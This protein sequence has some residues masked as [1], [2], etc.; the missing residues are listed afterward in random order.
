MAEKENSGLLALTSVTAGE[1]EAVK[2]TAEVSLVDTGAKG[3][4]PSQGVISEG[5]DGSEPPPMLSDFGGLVSLLEANN[6]FKHK[7]ELIYGSSATTTAYWASAKFTN[8]PIPVQVS[9]AK[10]VDLFYKRYATVFATANTKAFFDIVNA[11]SDG[12]RQEQ[13]CLLMLLDAIICRLTNQIP[14]DHRSQRR[15]YNHHEEFAMVVLIASGL[16]IQPTDISGAAAE[17]IGHEGKRRGPQVVPPEASSPASIGTVS[18]GGTDYKSGLADRERFS[19]LECD[20]ISTTIAAV[21]DIS[22]E[23]GTC[24]SRSPPPRATDVAEIHY[25]WTSIAHFKPTN[26]NQ[27]QR[28]IRTKIAVYNGVINAGIDLTNMKTVLNAVTNLVIYNKDA[29]FLT[30]N[31]KGMDVA[32][33]AKPSRRT[34]TSAPREERYTQRAANA[35]STRASAAA[36]AASTKAPVNAFGQDG[37][38]FDVDSL[39]TG[40]GLPTHTLSRGL[41]Q[42]ATSSG[43]GHGLTGPPQNTGPRVRRSSTYTHVNN[44]MLPVAGGGTGATAGSNSAGAPSGS[45]GTPGSI[46]EVG[47]GELAV[48]VSELTNLGIVSDY[49]TAAQ[50][51]FTDKVVKKRSRSGIPSDISGVR[52]DR[53]KPVKVTAGAA[54]A[55]AAHAA[56]VYAASG[57]QPP[58]PHEPHEPVKRLRSAPAAPAGHRGG[59]AP[60]PAGGKVIAT[61]A[62][63]SRASN[64]MYPVQDES[65]ISSEDVAFQVHNAMVNRV[66]AGW[67]QVIDPMSDHPYYLHRS[68]GTMTTTFPSTTYLTS[69]SGDY[70]NMKVAS[71]AEVFSPMMYRNNPLL[72][73]SQTGIL[74]QTKFASQLELPITST[75]IGSGS[76]NMQCVGASDII[77]AATSVAAAADNDGKVQ[78]RAPGSGKENPTSS[79]LSSQYSALTEE[80]VESLLS[81]PRTIR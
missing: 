28:G 37:H 74:G 68:S 32:T 26:K 51:T 31:N 61:R 25:P 45:E 80:G 15:N 7:R 75:S 52:Y 30:I 78:E 21:P 40:R 33:L 38:P 23:N 81:L 20:D 64:K 57:G 43:G 18:G 24:I 53:T 67:L 5:R 69:G 71:V 79:Y 60:V 11:F 48:G 1:V 76:T 3:D 56:A 59:V 77:A 44:Y 29:Y 49:D 70:Y 36:A 46:V 55:V 8:T 72:L 58:L 35:A 65:Q 2:S 10:V 62:V 16:V 12:V 14:N 50:L 42:A 34:F 63:T 17:R 13:W 4:T 9:W 47:G 41:V 54:A 19:E 22:I 27:N 6:R 73:A 39:S 66:P